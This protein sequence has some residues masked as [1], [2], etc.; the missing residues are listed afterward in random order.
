MNTTEAAAALGISPKT[1]RRHLRSDVRWAASEG[2]YTLSEADLEQL[3]QE[4]GR[5]AQKAA[6]EG[7]DTPGFT[8]EQMNDPKLRRQRLAARAMRQAKLRDRLIELSL[9]GVGSGGEDL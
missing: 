9:W 2:R 1:L 3:R 5:P 6:D 8:P 7:P 4:M